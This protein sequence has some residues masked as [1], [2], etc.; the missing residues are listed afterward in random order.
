ML[1]NSNFYILIVKKKKKVKQFH[2]DV[3]RTGKDSDMMIRRVIQAYE[4]FLYLK[5]PFLF[6]N[7]FSIIFFKGK[8][9]EFC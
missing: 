4:V 7:I 6:I 8:K 5:M 9:M 1:F 3:N 2:P